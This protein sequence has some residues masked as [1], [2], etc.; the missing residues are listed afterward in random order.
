M[1][2]YF[3]SGLYKGNDGASFLELLLAFWQDI[4][5]GDLAP[6]PKMLFVAGEHVSE[7]L[8]RFHVH[9]EGWSMGNGENVCVGECVCD[10]GMV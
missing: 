10:G 5:N 4:G 6:I 1:P 9:R 8:L 3:G 2:E 7:L